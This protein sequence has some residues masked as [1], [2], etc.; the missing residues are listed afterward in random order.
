MAFKDIIGQKRPLRILKG[1]LITGKLP[2]AFLFTGEPGIGKLFT[3][4]TFLK[5]LICKY[6]DEELNSCDNCRSCHLIDNF[7][8]PDL[9][10]IKPDGGQI[11]IETIRELNE[12]LNMS[13]YSS[14]LKMILIDEAEKLN[15]NAANAFLKTLEEPPEDALI[16][17][18]S[19]KP[20]A[21][22]DTIRSRCVRIPFS[23]LSLNE[24]MEVLRKNGATE[25]I[26][27]YFRIL[28]EGRPGILLNDQL[29]KYM[30]VFDSLMEELGGD[31]K[32]EDLTRESMTEAIEMTLL[33]L[34]NKLVQLIN[35]QPE[36]LTFRVPEIQD[37]IEKYKKLLSLRDL[38][39]L[40]LN[41]KITW[42]YIKA[43]LN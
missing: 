25:D 24:T 40:N 7:S 26:P 18:I 15:I 11:K 42:N 38:N 5:T 36:S 17:L 37:I 34:R 33:Y 8:F 9:R 14:P 19:E 31:K 35:S 12:F 20:E 13:T 41:K 2:H 10:F 21:L 16:I 29:K 32:I 3:A 43:V 23:P 27:S 6:R 4:R 28:Y 30:K 39:Q 1:F 22:P